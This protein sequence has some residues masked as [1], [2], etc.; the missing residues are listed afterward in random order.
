MPTEQPKIP[1]KKVAA[2][3]RRNHIVK[4]ALF[5]SFLRGK[6]TETSDVDFLVEFDPEHIPGLIRLARMETEL[7]MIIGQKVDLRT[8][9]DLSPYFREEVIRHAEVQYAEG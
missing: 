7:S 1:Q 8:P 2:F 4:L 9:Q 6:N 3:C 5:G